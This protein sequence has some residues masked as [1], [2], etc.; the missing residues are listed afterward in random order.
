MSS[1]APCPAAHFR[2]PPRLPLFHA[3]SIGG[4]WL[5]QHMEKLS[6]QALRELTSTVTRQLADH[7]LPTPVEAHYDLADVHRALAHHARS[8]RSGKIVLTG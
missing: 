6:A 8:N 3:V 1:T 7:T 2:F 4:F 5:P